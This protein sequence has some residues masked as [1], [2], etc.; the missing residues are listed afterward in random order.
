M[1]ERESAQRRSRGGKEAK[2]NANVTPAQRAVLH[3]CVA[4]A[5]QTG[6]AK[7]VCQSSLTC[8]QENKISLANLS[9][10]DFFS[11]GFDMSHNVKGRSLGVAFPMHEILFSFSRMSFIKNLVNDPF[12]LT[13]ISQNRGQFGM[14]AGWK[15]ERIIFNEAFEFRGVKGWENIG[16]VG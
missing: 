9:H 16:L 11:I 10:S 2:T 1:R 4:V 7:Q 3:R 6:Y 5:S 8:S 13:V 15:E 14:F 12:F